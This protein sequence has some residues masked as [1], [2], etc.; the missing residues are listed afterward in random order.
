[1]EIEK[2][3]KRIRPRHRYELEDL[4]SVRVPPE[5]AGYAEKWRE[6]REEALEVSPLPSLKDAGYDRGD[7]RVFDLRYQ[8][9][10]KVEI[11]GWALLPKSGRVERGFVISHGYGGRLAPD[12][13]F[14]F[15]N[16]ALMFPCARGISRSPH[17]PIS[18]EPRWHVRHD[19]DKPERYVLRGCV[20]DVWLAVSAMLRLAPYLEGHIGYLGTSFG[21]GVG[22]MALAWE[23]RV[24]KAH[25]KVP[26]FGH[27]MLRLQL[28]TMGSAASVQT[29]YKKE[30]RLVENTLQW[31]DAAQ[32]AKHI[33]IPMHLACALADPVVTPAGQFAIFNALSGP[34][35]LFTLEAG[36]MEYPDQ[37]KQ[38][39]QLLRELSSFFSDL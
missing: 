4:L 2:S 12:Y 25:L 3:A 14:P 32:S 29:L 7:W 26:S 34:K 6:W 17:P 28:K 39:K 19:I 9:T 22:A 21:G 8:S 36:H 38:E 37:E 33:K 15:K 5:P 24:Q 11:G 10:D 30:P 31:F 13:H 27:Q 1:M 23:D 20:E 35:E 18:H 16:A